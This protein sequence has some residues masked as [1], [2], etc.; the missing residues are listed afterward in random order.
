MTCTGTY[1]PHSKFGYN[2]YTLSPIHN[3]I[4]LRALKLTCRPEDTVPVVTREGFLVDEQTGEVLS[5][6]Y[7]FVLER[8]D[9]LAPVWTKPNSNGKKKK[10]RMIS[11]EDIVISILENRIE[12]DRVKEKFVELA[13]KAKKF[14]VAGIIA[15]FAVAHYINGISVKTGKL[16]KEFGISSSK[17]RTA[18]KAMQAMTKRSIADIDMQV[19]DKLREEAKLSD[20]D[21]EALKAKYYELKNMGLLSGKSVKSRVEAVL[22]SVKKTQVKVVPMVDKKNVICPVCGIPG[23]LSLLNGKYYTV[24]HHVGRRS[25]WHYLGTNV[26]FV[27][28][29]SK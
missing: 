5:D 25:S 22:K 24:E 7:R 23:K 13:Q 3:I 12:D 28:K 9:N 1:R 21:F 20:L 26:I 18:R 19:L 27:R 11:D 16:R 6:E 10:I 14:G 15:A 4:I 29:H 17:Y 8:Y 2:I